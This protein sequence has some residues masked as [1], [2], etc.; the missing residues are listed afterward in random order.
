MRDTTRILLRLYLNDDQPLGPGKIE[1]LETIRD[2]GSISE[3]ARAMR[4]SY[5]SAWLLVASMNALFR[6]PVVSTTLGGRGG[7]SAT[8]TAFGETLIHRY[9][10]MERATRRAIAR[11]VSAVERSLRRAPKSAG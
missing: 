6:T 11:D 3:A 1:L 10:S 5:R 9:R 4:M 7:G 8:I 2:G